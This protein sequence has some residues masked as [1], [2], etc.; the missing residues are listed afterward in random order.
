MSKKPDNNSSYLNLIFIILYL[1]VPLINLMDTIDELGPQW[2]FLSLLNFITCIYLLFKGNQSNLLIKNLFLNKLNLIYVAFLLWNF[3]SIFYS[4]NLTETYL[5]LS[6]LLATFIAF[7]NIAI[8]LSNNKINLISI[9]ITIAI[10]LLFQS[11]NDL[12][13]FLNGMYTTNLDTLILSIKENTGNKNVLAANLVIKIPF[14]IYLLFSSK[15]ITKIFSSFVIYLAVTIIII[16]NARASLLELL[17]I[18]I[19][20]LIYIIKCFIIDKSKKVQLFKTLAVFILPLT[21][22]FFTS[23]TLL[24]KAVTYNKDT[25]KV[26]ANYGTIGKR[27][28]AINS[29]AEEGARIALWKDA[30]KYIQQNPILGCGLGNWKITSVIYSKFRD[31]DFV[32]PYHS[33]NDFLETTTETGILGGLLYFS[34]FFISGITLIKIFLKNK[35]ETYS[36]FAIIGLM[37][38]G[39]YILDAALNFPMERPPMQ[40]MFALVLAIILNI[41][42]QENN[43]KKKENIQL[44][45]NFLLVKIY[46]ILFFLISVPTMYFTY[47]HFQSLKLQ[48]VLYFGEKKY[49]LTNDELD[50]IATENKPIPNLNYSAI[51]IDATIANNYAKNGN[52]EKAIYF[53]ERSKND[54]PY[55]GIYEFNKGILYFQQNNIDSSFK[56]FKLAFEKRPRSIDTY[57]NLIIASS[58]KKDTA[59][60]NKTFKTYIKYRNEFTAWQLYFSTMIQALGRGNDELIKQSDIAIKQFPD[61]AAPL[62][63]LRNYIIQTMNNTSNVYNNTQTSANLITGPDANLIVAKINNLKQEGINLFSDKKYKQSIEIY[64]ELMKLQPNDYSYIENVG[65]CY[66][67]LNDFNNANIYFNKVISTGLAKD[68]KSEFYNAISLFQI[69][70]KEEGCNMLNNAKKKNYDI[71]MIDQYKQIYCK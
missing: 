31:N 40:I 24:N 71:K 46:A 7:F 19:L 34:I 18:C 30:I 58:Q 69:N 44:R 2:F 55:L 21:F 45:N 64:I 5:N 37:A 52:F 47:A 15:A 29:S 39:T 1:S 49:N 11:I 13:I 67:I 42:H 51:P 38:L 53:L 56:F 57:K 62:N 70:K 28:T 12:R 26:N 23:N 41:V 14:C 33:H 59:T 8:L 4:I 9:S 48:K 60:L 25:L 3:L 16:L 65:I 27:A 43:V 68:G 54:N 66:Y 10:F 36:L 61:S 6:R 17:L 20:F 22:A 63:N 35:D 50:A 32:V